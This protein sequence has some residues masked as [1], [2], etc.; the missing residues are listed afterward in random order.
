[1]HTPTTVCDMPLDIKTKRRLPAELAEPIAITVE[2]ATQQA[3]IGV[4][5]IYK[6]I[7]SGRLKSKLVNGRRMIDYASF[8]QLVSGE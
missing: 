4:T 1:M 6:L 2:R 5:S 8:K 3:P 7:R